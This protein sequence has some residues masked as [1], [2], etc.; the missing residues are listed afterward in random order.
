M[1]VAAIVV[2]VAVL[3]LVV[4]VGA[5]TVREAERQLEELEADRDRELNRRLDDRR[6]E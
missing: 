5:R 4:V 3:T 2:V 6:A 1:D